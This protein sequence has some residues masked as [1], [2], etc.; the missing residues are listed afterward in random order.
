MLFLMPGRMRVARH[1]NRTDS[2]DQSLHVS[3]NRH[4]SCT[5]KYL[6]VVK[7]DDALAQ[8]AD[9]KSNQKK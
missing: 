4:R 8:K 3:Q 9:T 5:A 2:D 1:H 6:S 7:A